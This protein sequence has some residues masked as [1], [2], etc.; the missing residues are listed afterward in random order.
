MASRS[1]TTLP[2]P[3]PSHAPPILTNQLRDT[4]YGALHSSDSLPRIQAALTHELSATG[5]TNNLRLYIIQL[6]RTG[7]AKSYDE[8]MEK[9]LAAAKVGQVKDGK[10]AEKRNGVNGTAGHGELSL[11]H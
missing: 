10:E 11:S 3:S 6:L 4:L 1:Q 7:E 2:H 9:V 5:W 8:V